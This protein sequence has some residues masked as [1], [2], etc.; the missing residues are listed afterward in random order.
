VN[1]PA[2]EGLARGIV[3]HDGRDLSRQEGNSA[4]G[5]GSAD[6]RVIQGKGSIRTSERHDSILRVT[7]NIPHQLRII[8][9]SG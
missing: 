2:L 9:V 8:F 4:V 3:D 7:P 5:A 1:E 6:S